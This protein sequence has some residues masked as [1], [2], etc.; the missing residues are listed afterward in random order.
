MSGQVNYF[1]RVA[2]KG[3]RD[4]LESGY[5]IARYERET[6]RLFGVLEHGLAEGD[7]LCG[8]YSIADMC[9]FTWIDKYPE[10]GG[11]LADFPRLESWHARIAAR[12]AVRR[13][14]KVGST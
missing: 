10:N 1:K 8:D 12:P 14:L 3:E 2:A 6:R 4:P 7:Y 11:G 13:A 5:A 9:C